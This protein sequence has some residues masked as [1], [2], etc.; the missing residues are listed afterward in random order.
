MGV[1]HTL[2]SLPLAYTEELFKSKSAALFEHV[3]EA[4]A[5]EGKSVFSAAN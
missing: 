2:E 4:Y 3:Y 5:G 1:G